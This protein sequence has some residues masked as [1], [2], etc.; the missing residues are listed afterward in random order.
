M[1]KNLLYLL[2]IVFTFSFHSV[3]AQNDNKE[4]QGI[5]TAHIKKENLTIL[6]NPVRDGYLKLTFKSTLS[7]D[8]NLTV[9]NSLGKQVYTA[10]RS[11]NSDVQIFDISKLSAGI[12]FIRVG[13]NSSNFVKKLIIR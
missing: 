5:L 7:N 12:Y 9:I 4:V 3:V 6:T 11:I 13:T 2:L 8:L 10:K 1:K